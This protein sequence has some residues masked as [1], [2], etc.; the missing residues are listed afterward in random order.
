MVG[1]KSML[2]L[3]ILILGKASRNTINSEVLQCRS[4]VVLT[5]TSSYGVKSGVVPEKS[6]TNEG[7]KVE[8]MKSELRP[9]N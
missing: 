8:L 5:L 1:F 3:S 6:I 9:I 4:L 2:E 7:I